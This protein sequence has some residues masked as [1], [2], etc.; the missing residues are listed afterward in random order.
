MFAEPEMTDNRLDRAFS[1]TFNELRELVAGCVQFGDFTLSSG[2][3]SDF[4]FDGRLVTL[5]HRGLRLIGS[6]IA[7]LTLDDKATAVGGPTMGADPIAAAVALAT[8]PWPRKLDAFIVR[9]EAKGHGTG[10]Q[11]EGPP[12]GPESRVIVVEDV[13]TTAGSVL[14][15]IDAIRDTGAEVIR[16]IPLLDREEGAAESFKGAGVKFT[17]LFRKSDFRDQLQK[18][19]SFASDPVHQDAEGWWFWEET[20]ADRQG[21]F[22]SRTEA[23]KACREYASR[24]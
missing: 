17:P 9:K 11:I 8:A 19:A 24:L 18:A 3:K 2:K 6:T 4:Y 16:C 22:G 15:A 1:D 10:K 7:F 23:E 21:P 13:I 14:R 20:W 12:L 5:S